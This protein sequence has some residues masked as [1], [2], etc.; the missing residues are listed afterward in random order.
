MRRFFLGSAL[1]LFG[2]L[3]ITPLQLRADGFD[4]FTFTDVAND[5]S[6]SLVMTWQLPS[7][8]TPVDSLPGEYFA[9]G[10]TDVHQVLNGIDLGLV[11]DI[12]YF[13]NPAIGDPS[14]SFQFFDLYGLSLWGN[15]NPMYSGPESAPTFNA[16]TYSGLDLY[17]Y[18]QSGAPGNATLSIVS[19][20]E[21]S[22]ILML[23][24]GFMALAGV[25]LAKK[26]VA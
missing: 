8:P 11:P 20:P 17:N 18:D 23:L 9:V 12:F 13:V 24:V 15:P 16:G 5:G 26:A 25:L 7:S 10:A 3:L 14:T 19:T 4:S 6:F 21:P 2:L 1:V 22:S